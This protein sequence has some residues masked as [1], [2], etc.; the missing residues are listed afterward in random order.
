MWQSKSLPL[1]ILPALVAC[2]TVFLDNPFLSRCLLRLL[3]GLGR[4]LHL[5]W[6]TCLEPEASDTRSHSSFVWILTLTDFHLISFQASYMPMTH[7][8]IFPALIFLLSSKFLYLM[9]CLPSP[10]GCYYEYLNLNV[11]EWTLDLSSSSILSLSQWHWHTLWDISTPPFF[12]R[13]QPTPLLRCSDPSF[14]YAPHQSTN[15]QIQLFLTAR[16]LQR[17][18]PF[19]LTLPS[20][21]PPSSLPQTITVASHCLSCM[22]SV[23]PFKVAYQLLQ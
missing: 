12:Q 15:Q 10:S 7:K 13:T 6:S 21:K 16:M 3:R 19:L 14:F 2:C 17:L 4:E 18:L 23:H 22:S 11:S 8:L 1:K 20:P 5:G 9:T